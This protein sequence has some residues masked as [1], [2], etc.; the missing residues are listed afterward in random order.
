MDN[1][2]STQQ[3]ASQSDYISGAGNF[4]SNFREAWNTVS[5]Q[6]LKLET[7]QSYLEPG[8]PSFELLTQNKI[9]EA[10]QLIPEVRKIDIP[11]YDKLN[12]KHVDFV[13]CRPVVFPMSNYLK[14]EFACYKFNAE[15]GEKIFC[16]ERDKLLTIFETKA[17]HD[18]MVFDLSK[19]F[20]HNYDIDGKIEGG[21]IVSN[22]EYISSLVQLY[23]LIR[24]SSMHFSF[25]VP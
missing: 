7:R 23:S 10:I 15:H 1:L 14:W 25:F 11:L 16:V 3:I 19:A 24:A 22:R 8:N 18:F 20:I 5:S 17:L 6:V 13:R 9:E 2:I 21:W 12:S 4:F